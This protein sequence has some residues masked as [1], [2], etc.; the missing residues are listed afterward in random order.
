MLG[1]VVMT[2]AAIIPPGGSHI[3]SEM[4][5]IFPISGRSLIRTLNRAITSSYHLAADADGGISKAVLGISVSDGLE[6]SP[7]V[8]P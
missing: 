7:A 1:L 2:S 3:V 8:T 5:T 4:T 6:N